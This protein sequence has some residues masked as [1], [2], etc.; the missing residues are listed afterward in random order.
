MAIM[1][2]SRRSLSRSLVAFAFTAVG[3][4]AVVCAVRAGAPA[5]GRAGPAPRSAVL[6]I[7]DGMGPAYVTVTRVARGGSGGRLRMDTLP[8]TAICRTHSSDSPVTDSA[9]AASAMACGQKT[10]NG[11]LCED[12]TAI[13]AKRD[14]RKL[15]SIAL[16]A[17]NRGMRVGLVTTTTVTHATP[18][19]FYATHRDRD[20]EAEIASQAIASGFDLIFGGGRA[21]FPEDF[22]AAAR[23]QGWALRETADALRAIDDPG[24]HVLGLFAET[25][26]PYQPEI[27][28]AREHTEAGKTAE[29]K[30]G[31]AAGGPARGGEG[32]DAARTAPTLPEMTRRAVDI[33]RR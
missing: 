17:K 26:L 19:A 22:R 20:A 28:A 4:V 16:W 30:P 1:P 3:A 25:H 2:V 33:L 12:A 32:P 23:R 31:T 21:F 13:Y 27:E 14:G 8:Y 18:A 6:F 29:G 11:V 10:V 24:R 5:S 15:E 7:G 9:A